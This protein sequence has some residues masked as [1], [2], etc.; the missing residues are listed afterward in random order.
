[1]GAAWGAACG[2]SAGGLTPLARRIAASSSA[3]SEPWAAVPPAFAASTSALTIRPFGPVPLTRLRSSLASAAMRRASGEANTLP[4][5]PSRKSKPPKPMANP[6][7]PAE[8]S[9]WVGTVPVFSGGS[10]ASVWDLYSAGASGIAP[11]CGFACAGA[12]LIAVA[13]SP[14]SRRMAIGVL[15]A[16]PAVPSATRI[17]PMVPSSTA[18]SSIVALSV[19]IS[20]M[21]SPEATLSPSLTFHLA[22]A[23][24]V[25]VGDRAGIRI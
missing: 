2:L 6:A 20:A 11:P 3:S 5:G 14:S 13:S 10:G 8:T 19:S 15:T 7:T 24:S 21:M 25:M 18:S 16:T 17:L 9:R 4:F 12:A 1:M 23:P 22:S